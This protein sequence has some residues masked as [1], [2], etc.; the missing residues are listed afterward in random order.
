MAGH[1]G[2]VDHQFYLLKNDA[3]SRITRARCS[4][5]FAWTQTGVPHGSLVPLPFRNSAF[6]HHVAPP[7]RV[8]NTSGKYLAEGASGPQFLEFLV[9]DTNLIAIV[10]PPLRPALSTDRGV[11][12]AASRPI[13]RETVVENPAGIERR[14]SL[15]NHRERRNRGQARRLQ[16]RGEWQNA[17]STRLLKS[18]IS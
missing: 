14:R 18:R 15:R 3:V 7:S 4:R 8:D 6:P 12:L 10:H 11:A 16:L 17:V 2:Y 13:D 9:V 5:H 1:L